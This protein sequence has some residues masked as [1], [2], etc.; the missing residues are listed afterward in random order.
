M[1]APF[2]HLRYT[3]RLLRKSPGFTVT[4][5]LILS[6]GIGL[7]TAIF[8]L[9]DAA[10]LKPSVV[11]VPQTLDLGGTKE[12]QQVRV[13]FVSPSLAKV[14]GLPIKLGRWLNEGEDVPHGPLVAVLSEPF[15]R[16]HFQA[17]PNI[18]GKNIILS[19]WSFQIVGVAP[20]QPSTCGP[21]VAQ[22]Y[23]PTNALLTVMNWSINDRSGHYVD[24]LGRLKK[25]SLSLKRKRSWKPSIT[26]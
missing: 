8:S 20:M 23:V 13:F 10:M 14:G 4:A 17:D 24:C 18:V 9:I 1:H 19:G 25:G 2:Q 3:L 16:S 11:S 12:A 15:W 6:F 26:T 5:V 7:N 22:V 21:P